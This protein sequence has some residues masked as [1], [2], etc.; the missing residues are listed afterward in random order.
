[1][2]RKDRE[3]TDRVK[4]KRLYQSVIAAD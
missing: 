2:R 1:M 4:I 3:I